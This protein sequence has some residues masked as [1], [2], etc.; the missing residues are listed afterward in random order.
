MSV[1]SFFKNRRMTNSGIYKASLK[2]DF[3]YCL[4]FYVL[5]NSSIPYRYE[6]YFKDKITREEQTRVFYYINKKYNLNATSFEELF[7]NSTRLKRK[8]KAVLNKR[9]E[10]KGWSQLKNKV[11]YL[12]DTAKSFTANKGMIITFS[13]VDGAGK[14]T[15]ISNFKEVVEK[16]YRREVVLVRHRPGILPILSAVKVGKK[17]AEKQAGVKL[18]R[19]GQNK[20][21]VS[22]TL[23]FGYYFADY[24]LGQFYI[25]FKYVLR[26]KVVL[27]DRYYF[28]FI[29]DAKRSNIV[30]NRTIIKRLY[31]LV[32]KPNLN[33]FLYAEP[34]VILKRKQELKSA[35][36]V[37]LTSQYQELFEGYNES[38]TKGVYKAIQNHDFE[39][40]MQAVES[41]F[42]KVS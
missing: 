23:R 3:E 1:E 30:L 15:V 8:L 19:Q 6:S 22:S 17:E 29:N 14:T 7:V 16:K 21:L 25:Y 34:E 40:T 39:L 36:I 37:S 31:A 12:L 27:Y 28:D 41:S 5:N 4:L 9:I 2:Y 38:Q 11:N 24:L 33:F 32:W 18:P 35:D 42:R 26:G 10:N 13:G 20:S